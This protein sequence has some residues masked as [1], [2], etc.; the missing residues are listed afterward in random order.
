[1]RKCP[2]A[3]SFFIL[4]NGSGDHEKRPAGRSQQHGYRLAPFTG[5]A[6]APADRKK[7]TRPSPAQLSLGRKNHCSSPTGG[8][9]LKGG[10]LCASWTTHPCAETR[11][12]GMRL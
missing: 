12:S 11:G 5:A 8:T 7:R 9:K 10:W 6:G 3:V 1:M 2:I 4:R